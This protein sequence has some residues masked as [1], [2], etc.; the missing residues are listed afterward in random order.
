MYFFF[1]IP[2]WIVLFIVLLILGVLVGFGNVI[3]VIFTFLKS[4]I[5]VIAIPLL[6]ITII[7]AINSNRNAIAASI[8]MISN[9]LA[10][11]IIAA[12]A[13]FEENIG[14]GELFEITVGGIVILGIFLT[15]VIWSIADSFSDNPSPWVAMIPSCILFIFLL[16]SFS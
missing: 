9:L 16:N 12:C 2:G 15:G 8:P 3:I 7:G 13:E 11:Y 1:T 4:Y 14:M 5:L 6:I 10:I